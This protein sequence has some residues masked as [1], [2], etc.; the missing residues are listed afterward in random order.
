VDALSCF[1]RVWCVDFEFH[2][3]PGD[4]PAPLCCVA[5]ELHSGRLERRW[6]AD[7]APE[8]PP[9]ETD[10]ATLFV[11]Y[12]ASAELGCHLALDWP[13]PARILDLLAE[14]R[15]RTSG[16]PTPC[17]NGLLGALAYFGLDGVG[18]AE[19]QDMRGLAMRGGPYTPAE[20]TALLDYCQSDADALARLLPAM[21]PGIDLPR[22][23]LRGRY[24]T[25]AARMEWTG[26]PLDVDA[27][28]R[29]LRHWH[30]IKGRLIAAVDRD[31]GVFVP[32]GRRPIN[33]ELTIG[34]AI[35]DEAKAWGI[36]PH[37][38]ADAVDAL[39]RAERE[40]TAD[41][42]EARRAARRVTGLTTRRLNQ[43]EDS[44]RDYS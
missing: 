21:L 29:L 22:A 7:A 11:A 10:S 43:W 28:A 17:G 2:A 30:R 20:Q 1:R 19:K 36:D 38:L 35:L 32:A 34:A 8:A 42:F 37:Q 16:L 27:L 4:R 31:Y 44:G 41:L 6:L 5:R 26:I 15:C 14:F 9:Y 40:A 3:P 13:A 18:A 33:P 23:L 12:Y 24:M 39:W 25:A